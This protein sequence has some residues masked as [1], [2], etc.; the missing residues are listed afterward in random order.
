MNVIKDV[1][2]ENLIFVGIRDSENETSE[3]CLQKIRDVLEHIPD[4]NHNQVRISRCHRLGKYSKDYNCDIICHFNWFGDRQLI[5]KSRDKLPRG[6]FVNEDFPQEILDRRRCLRPI[7]KKAASMD[8]YKGKCSLSVDKLIIANR[9]YTVRPQ[10]NLDQLPKDIKQE[11]V[12]EEMNQDVLVYLGENS[13]LSNFHRAN[14]TVNGVKYNCNEQYIQ[15]K[16]CELFSLRGFK[17]E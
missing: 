8:K 11:S 1:K 12:A 4:L 6:C 10:N 14:F 5:Y 2:S 9:V 3:Q 7:L 13:V 15:S 17:D 16:K